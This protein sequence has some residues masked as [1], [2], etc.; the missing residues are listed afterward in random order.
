MKSRNKEK[1]KKTKKR[2]TFGA[3]VQGCKR[4]EERNNNNSN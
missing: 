3:C 1:G 2:L 4:I